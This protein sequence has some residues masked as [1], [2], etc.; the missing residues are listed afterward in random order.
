MSSIHDDV[1]G[2]CS[3][4]EQLPDATT[5]LR[6]CSRCRTV[7]Y[8][9][10]A[11]QTAH[12]PTHQ[13]S[14][15]RPNYIIEAWMCPGE[16]TNPAVKRTLSCPSTATFLEL[17]YALQLAFGWTD[18]HDWDF[19]VKDRTYKPQ[20]F[21]LLDHIRVSG[22]R[23]RRGLAELTGEDTSA[24]DAQMAAEPRKFL[25]RLKSLPGMGYRRTEAYFGDE[26][27]AHPRTS[28]KP[29][30]KLK[31]WQVLETEPYKGQECIYNYDFGDNWD[32]HIKIKG[33][34]AATSTF[35][36]TGG[37]G[38][39]PFEDAGGPQGWKELKQG[40]RAGT[41]SESQK[42]DMLNNGINLDSFNPNKFNAWSLEDVNAKL[43]L[44]HAGE[45]QLNS[46]G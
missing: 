22:I 25:L 24:Y 27:R 19:C 37:E 16:I 36:C 33:R 1:P 43:A 26:A 38:A 5:A 11:C 17:H 28:E 4:C 29:A 32:H 46:Q 39:R 12:W 8:C 35:T 3:S 14:C 6:R 9:S 2:R 42:F 7:A 23:D 41:C 20:K 13:P 45:L 21:N 15:K 10:N 31:L 40:I 34:E 18:T 44:W 30:N